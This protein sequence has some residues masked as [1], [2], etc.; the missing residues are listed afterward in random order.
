MRTAVLVA[1]ACIAFLGGL[2]AGYFWATSTDQVSSP[3]ERGGVEEPAGSDPHPADRQAGRN[4]GK[5]AGQ[6]P[7]TGDGGLVGRWER[8]RTDGSAVDAPAVSDDLAPLGYTG[9]YTE[10]GDTK[11]AVMHAPER[12]QP[13]LTLFCSG[14]STTVQLMSLDGA[15]VH[16]WR[17]SISELWPKGLPFMLAK[18]H[19]QFIRRAH[20]F[21][22]GDL[23]VVF[24]YIG[25]AKID[26]DSNPI[27]MHSGKNHH[28]LQVAPDGT[29]I[30]LGM[31]RR[32]RGP[33]SDRFPGIESPSGLQD[34]YVVFLSSAGEVLDR[35]SI[36]EAFYHSE[37]ASYL[38]A[39]LGRTVDVFHANSVD[40]IDA[41]VAAVHPSFNEGDILVSLRNPSALILIDPETK[42][43]TWMSVGQWKMQHQAMALENGNVL[44][45]DNQ[46]GNQIDPL[47]FDRSRVIE[48]NPPT[49]RIVWEYPQSASVEFFT[50]HLGYVQ[51]LPNGNT[52]VTEST[53]GHILE[54]TRSS[55][56]VWEYYSPFRAGE[57]GEWIA[58]IMGARR[59]D[60]ATLTF[61]K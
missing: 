19:T 29:V 58:T 11:G 4:P 14:H 23:I 48:Y 52:L 10:G 12:V 47:R 20:L 3:A 31:T 42:R 35:I 7:A 27:W 50:H 30:T 22:N 6:G 40:R 60:P 8:R 5:R 24:E 55:E 16:E 51:R 32:S 59:I 13:G 38:A 18:E 17:T 53:Q 1:L 34:N 9:G 61:L 43:V 15:I 37:Y 41:K 26:N 25:I 57:N 36:L 54:V 33:L 21:E 2:A 45:L 28:D 46:G 56:V 44:M 49:Q 39:I